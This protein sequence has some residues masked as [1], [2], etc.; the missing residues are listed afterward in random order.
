MYQ[1]PHTFLI[2]YS[3]NVTQ[4]TGYDKFYEAAQGITYEEA[5]KELWNE[6]ADAKHILY[7]CAD[8]SYTPVEKPNTQL[9]QSFEV[10]AWMTIGKN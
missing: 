4:S 10:N 6:C 5:C 7:L 2:K 9:N 3:E 8:G 1:E